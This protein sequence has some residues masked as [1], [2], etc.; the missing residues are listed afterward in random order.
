MTSLIAGGGGG[1]GSISSNGAASLISNEG[2]TSKGLGEN[3]TTGN[4]AV[5]RAQRKGGP[6][7]DDKRLVRITSSIEKS[8]PNMM[9]GYGDSERPLKSTA[10][11]LTNLAVDFVGEMTKKMVALAA[12]RGDAEITY[13]N[14]L[15]LIRDD[16]YQYDRAWELKT[17]NEELRRAHEIALAKDET[18]S[19]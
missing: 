9:Y 8:L 14:L 5:V 7:T 2:L 1:V 6:Y 16:S 13:Q 3:T 4:R 12:E 10:N 17:N 15:F 11:V 18:I 19:R